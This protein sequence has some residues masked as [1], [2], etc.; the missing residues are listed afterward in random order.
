MAPRTRL[1][2]WL[3]HTF[4]TISGYIP[5]IRDYFLQMKFKPK[6]HYAQGLLGPEDASDGRGRMFA[7]PT[8]QA[9][10]GIGSGSD[11]NEML[12]DEVIGHK[13]ALISYGACS[14]LEHPL[15]RALG[16]VRICVLAKEG[17]ASDVNLPAGA[18]AVIDKNDALQKFFSARPGKVVLVRPDR[19]IAGC[20]APA[21]EQ[22]FAE[23]FA[24]SLD[25]RN[26][27]KADDRN[28]AY[29]QGQERIVS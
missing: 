20:F 5:P 29:R 4:F 25:S 27:H 3:V 24:L 1:R 18:I 17:H 21:E 8:V 26:A 11:A 14:A 22:A 16:A 9:C 2:A 7:Q 19:Y 13:F 28:V 6:P 15:W 12:L 23:A 10:T